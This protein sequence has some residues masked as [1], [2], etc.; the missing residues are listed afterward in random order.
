VI[1][2]LAPKDFGVLD[3]FKQDGIK[4]T[5]IPSSQTTSIENAFETDDVDHRKV[6]LLSQ[7]DP[8]SVPRIFRRWMRRFILSTGFSLM[9]F[10]MP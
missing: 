5:A 1:T 8:D 9:N 2:K 7:T 6:R 10:R 4:V 3:G